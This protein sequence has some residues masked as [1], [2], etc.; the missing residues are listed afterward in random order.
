MGIG[1]LLSLWPLV[2]A[3]VAM[4]AFEGHTTLAIIAGFVADLTFGAPLGL[5]SYIHFPFLIMAVLC[6]VLRVGARS[7]MLPRGGSYTL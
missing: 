2:P 1:L 7:V 6:V 3:G 4:L 5:V